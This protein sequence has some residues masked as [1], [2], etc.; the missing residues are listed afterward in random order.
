MRARSASEPAVAPAAARGPADPGSPPVRSAPPP[1]RAGCRTSGVK[2]RRPVEGDVASA[3]A[4]AG[5]LASA[6]LSA[7]GV[8]ASD[9]LQLRMSDELKRL[10]DAAASYYA[11]S[12]RITRNQYRSG[13]ADES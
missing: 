11:E 13:T 4:S 6:R 3:Q 9:Y 12:L 5:D 8:L 10:F 7:Q 2:T 1:R